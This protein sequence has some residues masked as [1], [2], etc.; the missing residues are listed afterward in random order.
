MKKILFLFVSILSL[1]LATSCSSDDD[2]GSASILGKWH[3]HAS[4]YDGGTELHDHE[5]AT[6]KD[7]IEFNANNV[8]KYVIY[9]TSCAID[10]QD[11]FTWTQEGNI[12]TIESGDL[13]ITELTGST[14][15]LY[16]SEYDETFVFKR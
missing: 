2:K 4:I 9:N 16:D 1:S 14:L 6:K 11:T 3:H 5:C 12:I 10:D 7:Y 15:R 13:Q 8:Y